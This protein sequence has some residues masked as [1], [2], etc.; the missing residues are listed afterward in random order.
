MANEELKKFVV[1]EHQTIKEALQV[2]NDNWREVALVE[3][4]KGRIVGVI[5]DGDIRRGILRGLTLDSPAV[6]V[7]TRKYISV[8]PEE[9]RAAVLD[10]MK[11]LGV[12]HVPII[13]RKKR[14]IGIH[15][16]QELI[17]KVSKPN[18]AVIMAGGKG[19][20]L[21]PLTEY[22]PKPMIPVAGRPILERLVLQLVG[23]GI[24]QIYIS[25]NYL[26]NMIEEHFG[27]GSS[28]GCTIEYLRE[29]EALGT[30]GS[31]ALLPERLEHPLIV[32]N[33][34]LVTQVNITK[35][36]DFHEQEHV[37]ATIVSRPY[38]VEIPF[39]VITKEGNRLVQIQEKPPA[40]Y[41]INAGV[42]VLNPV[43]LKLIPRDREF[44]ITNLFD[45]LLK[46]KSL[47]GVYMLQEEWIDI[48]R[49]D[50]LHKANGIV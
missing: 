6:E 30:G 23:H 17:G 41:L 29:K 47:V 2:I 48:G 36:L 45:L 31:L 46:K 50:E 19:I 16:L 25:I 15:F 18:I 43:V 3:D 35:L 44:P 39:G 4:E 20:R 42:Y 34:D 8:G 21:R 13:D 22:C 27:D 32:M 40:N 7:M 28:F 5:T 37:E 12:R 49:H 24:Q 14:L 38:Q 1:L 11:A 33:G 26:G 10:I 9:D